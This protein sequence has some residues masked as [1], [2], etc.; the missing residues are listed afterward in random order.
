MVVWWVGGTLKLSSGFGLVFFFF[1]YFFFLINRM[2][3][4]VCY[5]QG[6]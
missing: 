2:P 5:D 4:L 3:F 6:R 1:V